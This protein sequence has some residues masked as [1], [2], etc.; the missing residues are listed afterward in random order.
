VKLK[1]GNRRDFERLVP[2]ILAVV[3]E[4]MLRGKRP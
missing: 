4:G 3:R 1:K 2:S